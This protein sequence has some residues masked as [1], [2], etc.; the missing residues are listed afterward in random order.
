MQPD[1]MEVGN[2]L[3]EAEYLMKYF[4]ELVTKLK[5]KKTLITE[6]VLKQESAND[7]S[8][9]WSET[10]KQLELREKLLTQALKF[11]TIA[12]LVIITF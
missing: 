4:A 6:S 11:H 7:L 5:S 2:D 1:S 10:D 9:L 12:K 8:L 3:E